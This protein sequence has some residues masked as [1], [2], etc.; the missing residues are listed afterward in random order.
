MSDFYSGLYFSRTY[1]VEMTRFYHLFF[2]AIASIF[3]ASAHG[4]NPNQTQ[5]ISPIFSSSEV[6]FTVQIHQANFSLPN[7]IH[8]GATAIWDGKWLLLAGRTNGLHG[9]NNTGNFPPSAQNTVVY[10]VEPRTGTVYSRDL[11]DPLSGLT[12]AQ[13]DSLSV[14]SPQSYQKGSTLYMT[15]GYGFDGASND[16]ITFPVLTAINIPKLMH[17]VVDSV[18]NE[19]AAPS[20]RQISNP[21][22]QV[23]G[24]AMFL[25]EGV[26]LL[27]MGQNFTG[28]YTP[29]SDGSYTDQVR[30]FKIIDNGKDLSI[31][32]KDPSPQD[33]NLRR[34]DLNV[35]PVIQEVI[36]VS[37]PSFIAFSGVFTPDVG[38]W[39][40]PVLIN[41][42]GKPKMPDPAK[43]KTFKQGMNNYVCAT[44]GLFSGNTGEMFVTFFGG[45][46]Y[47]FFT[48]SGFHTDEEFPFINQ[49]TTIKYQMK[50]NF[51]QYLMDA[52]Y[53]VIPSTGSNPGNPLLF[54]AG[55]EFFPVD[56]LPTYDNGVIKLD[57]LG[58]E[59][60]VI[61]HIVGGIQSTKPNTDTMSDSAASPYIFQVVIHPKRI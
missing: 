22:V 13:I 33:P 49:V 20:F 11:T 58:H 57:H 17:W 7:G 29:A 25:S 36:G 51:K 37:I 4:D 8:S 1:E 42:S 26:T 50:N 40:V 60:F 43:A 21:I 53:P 15:G 18:P 35:V 44:L 30:R 31:K 54:G 34:R 52:A 56:N 38:I 48:P 19:T 47:G 24:G 41:H 9:F 39:T 6:P 2:I 46:S 28:Q 59:P 16:F 32:P 27:I 55:A 10:V 5:D 23:T 14:T 3:S 45:I 61:G 12:Q